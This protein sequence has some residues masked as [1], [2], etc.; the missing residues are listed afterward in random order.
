MSVCP[1]YSNW[2]LNADTDFKNHKQY[3]VTMAARICLNRSVVICEEPKMEAPFA[4]NPIEGLC[5]LHVSARNE[6]DAINC[7]Y[8]KVPKILKE[9]YDASEPG[10]D[11]RSV[12]LWLRDCKEMYIGADLVDH[13]HFPPKQ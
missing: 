13:T 10:I 4:K 9:R 7:I 1:I 6:D 8:S 5:V 2:D 3:L 11:V 12:S